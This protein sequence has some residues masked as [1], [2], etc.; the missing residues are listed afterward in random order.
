MTALWVPGFFAQ[1][2]V[3]S[4]V[5]GRNKFAAYHHERG[6]S[7]AH[8]WIDWIGGL[9]FEVAKPNDVIRTTTVR[10]R[11]ASAAP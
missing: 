11:P 7:P 9:P 6:M 4:L 3:A 10:E 2:C 5:T 8:D 1:M